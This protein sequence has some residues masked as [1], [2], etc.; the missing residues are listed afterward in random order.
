MRGFRGLGDVPEGTPVP[1]A[2]RFA[3]PGT[4]IARS[5]LLPAV[6]IALALPP[7]CGRSGLEQ[8]DGFWERDTA[9]NDSIE[10]A[11]ASDEDCDDGLF[12]TGAETCAEGSLSCRAPR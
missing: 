2:E 12:C 3:M 10:V 8:P 1:V 4:S 5:R 7:G 6:A 9:E 11:C